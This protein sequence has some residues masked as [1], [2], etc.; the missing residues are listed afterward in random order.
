MG[1]EVLYD[2]AGNV[3]EWC[4]DWHT[5][6]LG[7]SPDPDAEGPESGPFR[8]FRGGSW[9]HDAEYL[10]A[11][12]RVSHYPDFTFNNVGFRVARTVTP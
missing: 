11:A 5:C 6:D 1:G 7:T 10:R 9:S 3:W 2:M 12:Y 4:N 8:E